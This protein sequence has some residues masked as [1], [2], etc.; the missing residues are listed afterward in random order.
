MVGLHISM[1]KESEFEELVSYSGSI[2]ALKLVTNRTFP[3]SVLLH[4]FCS[5]A[6]FFLTNSFT[7][8]Q[9]FQIFCTS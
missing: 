8:F 9:F 7:S 3:R 1:E 6:S 2:L 5:F 4:C